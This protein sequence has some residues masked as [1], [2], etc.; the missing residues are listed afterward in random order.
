[1]WIGLFSN[2]GIWQWVTGESVQY[3]NW[4]PGNP[5]SP[6]T[7]PIMDFSGAWSSVGGNTR[8]EY[9]IIEID[10]IPQTPT[11]SNTPIIPPAPLSLPSGYDWIQNPENGHY[12]T[13]EE[14][15][16]L[17]NF[18]KENAESIGGHLLTISDVHERTLD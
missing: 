9:S 15:S 13:I 2:V 3:T 10:S 18:A 12:Y 4:A 14:S 16:Q 6:D 5:G 17:W 11:S 7:Y 1:L 8:K